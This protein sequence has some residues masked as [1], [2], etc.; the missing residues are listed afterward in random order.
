MTNG[1]GELGAGLTLGQALSRGRQKGQIYLCKSIGLKR[2]ECL[3]WQWG[4]GLGSA[5]PL[6]AHAGAAVGDRL[7]GPDPEQD[8]GRFDAV[9][10]GELLAFLATACLVVDRYLVGAHA[11]SQQHGGQLGVQAEPVLPYRQ[12]AE[13]GKR[14]QLQAAVQVTDPGV[15]QGVGGERVDPV[16]D[17]KPERMRGGR[18]ERADAVDDL[19]I[20][21]L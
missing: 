10:P 14:K 11:A 12:L 21:P 8:P 1:A 18:P 9:A 17:H 2:L 15:E 3:S 7:L 4:A 13:Q 5:D 19:R 20:A 16:A 6:L